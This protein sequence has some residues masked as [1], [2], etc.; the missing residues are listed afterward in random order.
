MARA[1][2]QV[3]INNKPI[4]NVLSVQMSAQK[5][6]DAL[7]HAQSR[8][9]PV[10]I[11]IVRSA[12]RKAVATGFQFATNGNGKDV[13]VSTVFTIVDDEGNTAYHVKADKALVTSWRLVNSGDE[14][15]PDVELIELYAGDVTLTA[16]GKSPRLELKDFFP[17]KKS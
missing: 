4:S 12:S 6:P 17:K 2:K 8:T 1:P 14:G 16:G 11:V 5:S 7:G 3:K 15:L 13:P 9:Q 10:Q